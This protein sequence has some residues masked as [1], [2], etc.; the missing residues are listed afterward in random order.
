M[1]SRGLDV[2]DTWRLDHPWATLYSFGMSHRPVA[3]TVGFLGFGT[4]FRGLYDAID[5]IGSVPAGGTVLD[6]PCG[7]GIALSGLVGAD[8]GRYIAADISPAMLRRT[9]RTAQ[10]LGVTV[11]T[12]EADVASLPFG[13]ASIDL[14]LSL[15]GL[16]CFPAPRAAVREIARVTRDRI[17]LTWV[18]SDVGLR[19]RP[20]LVGGRAMGVV[21]PSAAPQDVRGWLEEAGFEVSVTVEGAFAYA[22]ARRAASAPRAAGRP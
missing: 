12:L 21:G 10:R 11:E 16:H 5:A 7:A 9:S 4:T 17:E 22:S 2:S 8:V 6:V 14:T 1:P 19:F 20:I 3:R 13:D 18:R 15:T